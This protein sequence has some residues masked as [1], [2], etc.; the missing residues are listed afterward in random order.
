MLKKL[1]NIGIIIWA[2]VASGFAILGYVLLKRKDKKSI[3]DIEKEAQNAKEKTRQKIESTPADVLIC[4]ATNADE[5][6]GER[7]SIV[8]RFRAE[9]RDRLEQKLHGT[10]SFNSD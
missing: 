1:K 7:E 3:N 6:H 8:E 4:N 2:V 5:L 10:G 9:V